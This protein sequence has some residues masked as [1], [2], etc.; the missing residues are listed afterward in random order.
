MNVSLKIM[1]KVW[2]SS[3]GPAAA[4]LVLLALADFA[5]DGGRCWPSVT[6]LA[7]KCGLSARSVNRCIADLERDGYLTREARFNQSNVY[8]VHATPDILSGG[9]IPSG[10]DRM[11]PP[12]CQDVTPPPDNPGALT[13][14]RTT[15]EPS[16]SASFA[17]WW[18]VYP[19]RTG[20]IAAEKAYAKAL[21]A[22]DAATL[23][24]AAKSYSDLK[25]ETE[26]RFILNP[27]SWLNQGHWDDEDIQAAT[28]DSVEEWLRGCWQTYD[29]KSIED[30]SGLAFQ[31]PDIPADVVDVRA[32]NL[33]ARRDWITTHREEITQRIM[34]KEA[35]A[36]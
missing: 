19:K 29:T 15:K 22:V 6:T 31:A 9:D 7:K 1:S 5:D 14:S 24:A 11:S 32:F 25:A 33:Q 10:G 27:A 36:A 17:D 12:P 3:A 2:D 18:K 26:K 34:T 8:V 21:K 4:R 20:K 23:L 13:V 28:P 16:I 35:S 30:R